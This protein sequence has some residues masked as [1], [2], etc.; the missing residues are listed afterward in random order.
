MIFWFK[1]DQNREVVAKIEGNLNELEVSQVGF[2]ILKPVSILDFRFLLFW[3]Q[4]IC[5]LLGFYLC[6]TILS[7]RRP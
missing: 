5:L 7:W 6:F 1:V 2:F 4:S 3:F